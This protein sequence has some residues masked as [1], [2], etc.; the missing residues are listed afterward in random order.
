MTLDA[1]ANDA[2]RRQDVPFTVVMLGN[3]DGVTE[4]AAAGDAAPGRAADAETAYRIFSMT[5]LVGSLA[6][7]ILIERGKLSMETEVAS[8]LP[9][10]DDLEVLDGW[11]GDTPR[12]RKPTTAATIRHLATHR[13]GLEY[14]FWNPD[15]ARYLAVTGAP[16]ILTGTRAAMNYPLMFDPGTRWG[17]GISIDWLGLV[18]EAVDG[19]R[20]DAFCQEEIFA[21]LGMNETAFEPTNLIDRLAE[22]R[23]R[24]EDGSFQPHDIAPPPQPEIYGMG[25]CLYSTAPDYMRLLRML[26]RGGELDGA[27]LL[28][29]A[30]MD[31][32]FADQMEGKPFERMISVAP[33]LSADVETLPGGAGHGFGGLR[34]VTDIEGRRRAG[35]LSWAGVLNTHWWADRQADLC[36]VVMTQSLPFAEPR[37]MA[38][39][40]AVER[41]AYVA[42]AERAA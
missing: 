1:L 21:P 31:A 38:F 25:H 19:R 20:M 32:F 4:T 28:S 30:S 7:M 2:V 34:N 6:A 11:D 40:E 13:S 15:M 27:R 12:L 41:H 9:K 39:Y 3:S 17:Y 8:I 5:K 22:P 16:S 26:L 42:H 10:W 23:I 35:T 36:G 33:P 29:E 18:V 37:Y 24:V 14:E